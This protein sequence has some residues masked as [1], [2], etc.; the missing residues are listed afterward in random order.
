M[1]L[2]AVTSPVWLLTAGYVKDHAAVETAG[3]AGDGLGGLL[4]QRWGDIGDRATSGLSE[5]W[6][7]VTSSVAV[8]LLVQVLVVALADVVAHAWLG[9]TVGKAITSLVVVPADGS[10]RLR[11][12]RAVWRTSITVLLPALGWIALVVGL[13]QLSISL[14]LLG[15][16]LLSLSVVEC[17]FLRGPTCWHDR[18]SRSLVRPVDWAAKVAAV[19]ESATHA[20]TQAPAWVAQRGRSLR[21]RFD[22][23]GDVPPAG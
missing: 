8:T 17:L 20:A 10:R 6:G 4:S 22:S 23:R 18:S 14:L 2:L 5:V 3:L 13:F 11:L 16:A 9:R 15:C 1:L 21:Q 12:G 7:V 19:R